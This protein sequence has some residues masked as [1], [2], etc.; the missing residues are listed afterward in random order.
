MSETIS[1]KAAL[2]RVILAER[3]ALSAEYR[4]RCASALAGKASSTALRTLLPPPGAIIAGYWPI[5]SEM[6]P[7]PLMQALRAA[8]YRIALPRILGEELAFH[9]W[10]DGKAPVAGPFGTREPAPDWP[11]AAPD[12]FLTPLAAFDAEGQRLGYGRGFYD[13]A[14]A[15]WPA[16]KRVGLAF[17]AQKVA[18][19]PTEAHDARLDLVLTGE[20]S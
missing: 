11:E 14:F 2:R 20:A 17:A 8:G 16:A 10:E 5:R 12:L 19:V 18:E 6:D 4:A 13:R 3:D 15:Q 1:Q 7:R 9:L